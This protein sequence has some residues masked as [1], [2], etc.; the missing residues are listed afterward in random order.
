MLTCWH[1]CTVRE[2]EI[3]QKI[4]LIEGLVKSVK[5]PVAVAGGIKIEVVPLLI[6]AGARI[7]IVGGA[8]T[9]SPK[10]EEATKIFV[11]TTR[12]IWKQYQK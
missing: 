7:L 5:I 6:K 10:P 1:K 9:K 12:S 11:N 3:D 8:I 2:R 4:S